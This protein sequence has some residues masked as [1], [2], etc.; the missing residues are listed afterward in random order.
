MENTILLSIF[1]LIIGYSLGQYKENKK[2]Q[3][4]K[5]AYLR[6]IRCFYNIK[7]NQEIMEAIIKDS[8]ALGIDLDFIKDSLDLYEKWYYWRNHGV[9]FP[10]YKNPNWSAYDSKGRLKNLKISENT[11]Y[12]PE[13]FNPVRIDLDSYKALKSRDVYSALL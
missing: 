5:S 8:I 4:E 11:I 12:I 13:H 1:F 9:L 6:T 10:T 2:R 3:L 7:P